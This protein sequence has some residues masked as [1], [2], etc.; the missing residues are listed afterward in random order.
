M[1]IISMK[2]IDFGD[3]AINNYKMGN[4]DKVLLKYRYH[5]E[6]ISK[7]NNF[8]QRQKTFEISEYYLRRKLVKKMY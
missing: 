2:I 3:I 6:Q 8:L 1:K 7:K 5:N 4:I